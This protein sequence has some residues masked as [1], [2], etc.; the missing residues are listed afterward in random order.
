MPQPTRPSCVC[1][2]C[3]GFATVAITTGA[4]HRDGTRKTLPVT[5]PTCRGTG[6]VPRTGVL[7]TTRR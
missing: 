1:R 3:D 6:R 4:R 2:D 5:C 7:S